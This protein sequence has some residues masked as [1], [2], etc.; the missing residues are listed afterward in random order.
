MEDMNEYL[1]KQLKK[2]YKKLKSYSYYDNKNVFLKKR[3][4]EFEKQY[5]YNLDDV[6][7]ELIDSIQNDNLNELIDEKKYSNS[8]NIR[9]VPKS[10]KYK[11]EETKVI[12]NIVCDYEYYVDKVNYY[13]DISIKAQIIG[14]LWIVLF[15]K[16]IEKSYKKYTSGNTLE[17]NIGSDNLKLFKPYYSE[18][19]KWRDDAIDLVEK[20]MDENKRTIMMSLD[21]KEYFYS[22]NIDFEDKF[23]NE[24]Q[25]ILKKNKITGSLKDIYTRIND[26]VN[27]V[28]NKYSKKISKSKRNLLPIG[29]LPSC[30]LCNWYLKDFDREVV[31]KINPLYYKRYIDDIILVLNGD[32]IEE[33]ELES[34]SSLEEYLLKNLFCDTNIMKSAIMVS[35]E[36]YPKI[37]NIRATTVNSFTEK[38]KIYELDRKED[39]RRFLDIIP[40][41]DV[42]LKKEFISEFVNILEKYDKV[43]EELI[44]YFK[45]SNDDL[46][47]KNWKDKEIGEKLD[48]I[49][50]NKEIV[51][52]FT[53]IGL[54]NIKIDS[55]NIKKIFLIKNFLR[56][57]K[58]DIEGAILCIQDEKIRTYD[59]KEKGSKAII[60]NFKKEIYENSSIFNY[61]PEKNELINNF[62][63]EVYKIDYKDDMHKLSNIEKIQ[64]NRYNM[65]IFLARIIY[66]DKLEN[67]QYTKDV[68]EKILWIF[69]GPKTIE[70]YFL[71]DKVFTYYLLNNKYKYIKDI[72]VEIYSS[73]KTLKI[74]LDKFNLNNLM[75][76]NEIR[77]SIIYDLKEYLKI[78][79]SM[80]YSLNDELFLD[81]IK[82]GKEAKNYLG[83]FREKAYIRVKDSKIYR[84]LEQCL[85]EKGIKIKNP[86]D[87]DIKGIFTLKEMFRTSNMFNHSLVH[88]TLLNYCYKNNWENEEFF[89]DVVINYITNA[90]IL[91]DIK[92]DMRCYKINK[93]YYNCFCKM[94]DLDK[95][96]EEERSI[97]DK[98]IIK[99]KIKKN[100]VREKDDIE[101]EDDDESLTNENEVSDKSIKCLNE[102]DDFHKEYS[103]RYVNLHECILFYINQIMASG[104]IISKEEEIEKGIALFKEINN[105]F[106]EFENMEEKFIK[107][108]NDEKY[109]IDGRKF[110]NTHLKYF[111]SNEYIFM[112][113]DITINYI[114]TNNGKKNDKLKI[115]IV[116]MQVFENDLKKSFNKV[117]NLASGRLENLNKLLNYAV[118]NKA[119]MII[120]PEVSIPIQWMD[121]IANFSKNHDVAIVCGLEHIIY[122][123]GLCCNYI[124]T[125]LPDKYKS[126][127]YAIIKLRLK[128]HYSPNEKEWVS[129]YGW[130]LPEKEEVWKKEYDLFR[131]KGIDFSTFSC[132]ELA[133]IKD[134]SLFS[135]YVDLL[136]GSV[137]N[138]DINYYSN[139]MESL[140]RDV[141]CY[142]AHVNNSR[143][144]D[145]RII[146]P[147]PTNEKNLLQISGGINDTVLIGEIDVKALRE[148]QCLEYNLQMKN[149]QFKPVPPEFN[150]NNVKI[151]SDLP[152]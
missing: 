3:I 103:P 30:I 93:N 73:L 91:P 134:R 116:N 78:I 65:S 146:K 57:T 84:G 92:S 24:F 137:H 14:V 110:R 130:R 55:S 135:S 132:F 112:Q 148:F 127:K 77:E 47:Y 18:Y 88:E 85:N 42:K 16:D 19:S 142:F 62:D 115:A 34:Y 10:V 25:I 131:W 106:E 100:D 96:D 86:N 11:N 46:A 99:N 56:E 13:L 54:D 4:V 44:K 48:E 152:L 17:N 145:N 76:E 39:L 71:W 8:F 138:K 72:F 117:P 70:F 40:R 98:C 59:F 33:D 27:N 113:Q 114:E 69:T 15:G 83:S 144:G 79:I 68:D 28:I 53:E 136:V 31:R 90:G 21:I 36:I 105:F 82:Y 75:L 102:I 95:M 126:Y 67:T 23:E 133:N 147:A 122:E 41:E 49:C 94:N 141:H 139:V 29:F 20:R 124:A 2:A 128:N 22:T 107:E 111:K 151:R 140:S 109:R 1:E 58:E 123:N 80:I 120:F 66:S 50:N 89:N 7:Q 12:S 32:F 74:K 101:N 35:E 52:R 64:I 119:E 5:N 81:Y 104:N 9:V 51:D 125:I 63:K 26:F 97:C 143:M 6:F 38:D 129:G 37:D 121:V 60:E 150:H 43:N 61:L 118:K 108:I 87:A 149:D 45:D